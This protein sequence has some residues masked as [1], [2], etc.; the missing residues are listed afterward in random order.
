MER[1]AL[2]F[3]ILLC[4]VKLFINEDGALSAQRGAQ[5]CILAVPVFMTVADFFRFI[6]SSPIAALLTV[7]AATFP[8]L[9]FPTER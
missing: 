2:T 4:Q 5:I 8:G 6:G 7:P 3:T 1:S 9:C